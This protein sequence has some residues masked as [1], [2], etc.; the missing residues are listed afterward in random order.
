MKEKYIIRSQH[1][2]VG[3]LKFYPVNT[4]NARD[5]IKSKFEYVPADN[6]LDS[7]ERYKR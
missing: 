3:S 7:F 6:N 4:N 2:K 1:A 5:S